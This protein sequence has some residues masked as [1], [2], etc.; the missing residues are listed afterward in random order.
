MAYPESYYTEYDETTQKAHDMF[1]NSVPKR[2]GRAPAEL[3]GNLIYN[4]E[5]LEQTSEM[6]STIK[7]YVDESITRFVTGDLH[8]TADSTT[9]KEGAVYS[10]MDATASEQICWQVK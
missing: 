3:V 7:S 10:R 5:E 2:H 9:T 6:W 1:W 4:A 8:S